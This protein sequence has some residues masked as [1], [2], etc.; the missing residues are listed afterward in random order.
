[1]KVNGYLT[2]EAAFII[3]GLVLILAQFIKLDFYLHDCMLLNTTNVIADIR[4]ENSQ[5]FFYDIESERISLRDLIA[6]PAI[7]SNSAFLSNAEQNISRTMQNYYNSSVLY[8]DVKYSG[9][10]SDELQIKLYDHGNM[11]RI[12]ESIKR[13]AGGL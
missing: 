5:I 10:R 3:T 6:E 4:Y 8:N 11:I 7:G 1:M 2:V 12:G 9:F 13:L